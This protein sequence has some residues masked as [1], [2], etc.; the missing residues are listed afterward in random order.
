MKTVRVNVQKQM[1]SIQM[2]N[3]TLRRASSINPLPLTN[4]LCSLPVLWRI[5]RS[6]ELNKQLKFLFVVV[7]YTPLLFISACCVL[8]GDDVVEK[9]RKNRFLGLSFRAHPLNPP[10]PRSFTHASSYTH[11][12]IHYSAHQSPRRVSIIVICR[13][14]CLVFAGARAA[15]Q[16]CYSTISNIY[17]ESNNVK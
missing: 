13:L 11:Y 14:V 10:L 16:E 12:S 4:G 2:S 1:M 6:A 8:K 5:S 3:I 15:N 9:K 17:T 7:W